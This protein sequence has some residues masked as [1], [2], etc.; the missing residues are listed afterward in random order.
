MINISKI[1]SLNT[2]NLLNLFSLSD[3][4][5]EEDESDKI[6]MYF[7]E[8]FEDIKLKIIFDDCN[9]YD[10]EL[11]LNSFV[12]ISLY[13]SDKN[14]S[15]NGIKFKYCKFFEID[16]KKDFK[17]N[18]VNDMSTLRNDWIDIKNNKKPIIKI[19]SNEL[20]LTMSQPILK[21]KMKY[22]FTQKDFDD[23]IAK[24][25]KENSKLLKEELKLVT[26]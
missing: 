23:I 10:I 20:L 18:I 13:L 16:L 11:I 2:P 25:K 8:Y 5:L 7:K 19:I 12:T 21:S 9:Y 22:G 14:L 4:S 17:V 3:I 6:D 26:Y 24:V 15:V 1:L